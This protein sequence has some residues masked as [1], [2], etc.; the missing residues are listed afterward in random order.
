VLTA[1]FSIAVFSLGLPPASLWGC[2]AVILPATLVL[3]LVWFTPYQLGQMLG[4]RPPDHK[5]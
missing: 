3:N 2:E 1:T 5:A 4:P